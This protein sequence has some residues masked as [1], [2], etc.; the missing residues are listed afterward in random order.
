[1]KILVTGGAG[2]VGSFAARH[3]VAAGHEVAVLDN[4]SEGHRAAAPP[5]SL[6]VG[7]ISDR[8]L[9]G[10]TLR[11]QGIEAVMHFAAS[12][13]VGESM[14]DPRAYYRNNVAGSLELLEVMLDHGVDR[15]VFSGSC[16][17]YGE[18]SAMPLAEDASIQPE[19]TY[20][21]TKHVIEQMIRDFSRAYGL[22]YVLLRYFN[23]AG[24]S[25][26]GAH[27]EDHQP[28]IHL[29]P[30]V[31]QTVSG[32][33]DS[34]QV[35][36]DDYDTPDG[37]CIRDYVHVEDLARAHESA[38]LGIPESGPAPQGRVYNLGTGT[39]NS[40]LGVIRAVER[41]TGK[42]V[43]YEITGRRAGDTARL[44]A[45]AERAREEL[46]WAPHYGRIDEIVATAWEW[47]RK[48]PDGYP[49]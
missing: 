47:Q 19:S 10:R 48:N 37:T 8:E 4:L 11:E 17:V 28:E 39:G 7:E 9:V 13:Y 31:L 21:F 45:A 26:D 41:V 33:R 44:V 20:A 43:P 36:G 30:L 16:S 34:L 24:G 29:I 38:L 1:M 3:L 23:A 12:S 2:Y 49:E 46:D 18:T 42:S 6:I 22:R 14:T 40:V 27:G 35:F 15:I 32:R 5:G 25:G